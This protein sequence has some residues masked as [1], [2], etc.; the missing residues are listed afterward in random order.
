MQ[1]WR[2]FK[3]Q[4]TDSRLF[5]LM[6]PITARST[7]K[8][9]S[10]TMIL[11]DQKTNVTG[12]PLVFGPGLESFYFR[13][14]VAVHQEA[15]KL[16][17]LNSL[18]EVALVG[19]TRNEQQGEKGAPFLV[20]HCASTAASLVGWYLAIAFPCMSPT[21]TSSTVAISTNT[22]ASRNDLVMKKLVSF[23]RSK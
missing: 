15:Q 9:P 17:N 19:L 20:S 23:L 11:K 4:G 12:G 14:P 3:Y 21:I 22:T 10:P 2:I 1:Y 13:I 6:K 5:L 18:H 16:G 7:N 8:K